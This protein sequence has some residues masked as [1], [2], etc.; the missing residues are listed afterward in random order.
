MKK[1]GLT[2]KIRD[3]Q[4]EL[5]K[6]SSEVYKLAK[7]PEENPNP[8]LRITYDGKLLY[9]NSATN[10]ILSFFV[11]NNNAI[12]EEIQ[13][14]L[15][16]VYLT[17]S[18]IKERVSIKDSIY[19]LYITPFKEEGYINIYGN[20]ITLTVMYENELISEK[21]KAEKLSRTKSQFL[22]NMSHEIR[23][24]LNG[25]IG[26]LSLIKNTHLSEDQREY[27]N[28]ITQ[29]SDFL[30]T[31][32]N[33]VLEFSKIESGKI[34][35]KERAFNLYELLDDLC[36]VFANSIYEKNLELTM[37]ISEDIPEY[38]SSDDSRIRQI[39]INLIG[40]AIK[41]T[42]EGEVGIFVE[43]KDNAIHFQVK[44]TGCGIPK[45][46]V[47]AIFNA[48]TQSDN[49]DTR[50]HGGTGLGLSICKK[51]VHAMKG[52]LWVESQLHLGSTFYIS[53][54]FK[55]ASKKTPQLK[56]KFN[57]N[58]VVIFSPN[59]TVRKNLERTISS[60]GLSPVAYFSFIEM[61]SYLESQKMATYQHLII[62][63]GYLNHL[64][65]SQIE[66][67]KQLIQSN[68]DKISILTYARNK[69]E[70]KDL[71]SIENLQFIFKPLKKTILNKILL[72]NK[73]HELDANGDKEENCNLSQNTKILI[74]EDNLINQKVTQAI[75][76]TNGYLYDFALNGLE[77]L[78]KLK[79]NK[80]DL[81]LMDCQMPELD[82]F[83]TTQ[84]FREFEKKNN[85]VMTPIIAMTASA[86]KET[87]DKCFKY[88][89]NDFIS[90]PLKS[91]DL[92]EIIEKNTLEANG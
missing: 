1:N 46:N 19:E 27:L 10:K 78:E 7:F 88:K 20:N 86:F 75:L 9:N 84:Q 33:E 76:K 21:I 11:K 15:K 74:V 69:G 17:H 50:K 65:E 61:M 14:I 70:T 29:S 56:P 89:M 68:K 73:P 31:I 85:Q 18:P 3:L 83:E 49:T 52:K 63:G 40:N 66:S 39:L 13:E 28:M 12:T 44:D 22:A 58:N 59:M 47:D 72:N 26:L 60:L 43:L 79:S 64:N 80:Y 6:S 53:L 35:L 92:I 77:A 54:P 2:R 4:L 41:F 67:L 8:V 16:P 37:F 82:G 24:P 42:D 38:I 62:D 55:P 90:K 91:G 5:K 87:Q 81:I 25:I 71:L 36:D 51:I 32:I 23:T 45:G 34:E 30:L 57:Q 48:F